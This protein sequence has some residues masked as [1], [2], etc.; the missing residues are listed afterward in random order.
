M[1]PAVVTKENACIARENI[2]RRWKN[3][4]LKK[5]ARKVKHRVED[6]VR[7]SRAKTAFE[8]E[9]EAKWNEEIFQIYVFSI[10]EPHEL[11]DLAGEVIDGIFYEQELAS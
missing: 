6:L 4:T 10:G 9:Y 1:Q 11:R 3:E 8:K 2:A 7:I 5:H